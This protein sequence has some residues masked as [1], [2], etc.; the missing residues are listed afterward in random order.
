MID[1]KK[2]INDLWNNDNSD[3][4]VRLCGYTPE[5]IGNAFQEFTNKMKEGF[6]NLINEQPSWNWIR[7]Q[8][9]QPGMFI[10]VLMYVP[11]NEPLPMV[12]EGY[13]TGEGIW[14]SLYGDEY[15]FWDVPFWMHMPE[16]PKDGDF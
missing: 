1:E 2:L 4:T 8:D 13:L 7:T 11:G 16:P 12:H 9:E 15:A 5:A 10:S 6:T 14:K 3:F